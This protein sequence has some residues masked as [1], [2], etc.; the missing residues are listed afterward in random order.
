MRLRETMEKRVLL[1]LPVSLYEKV[2]KIATIEYR[3]VPSVIREC[4]S[5]QIEGE[6][7]TP[8]E[9]ASIER[10]EGEYRQGKCVKWREVAQ[11]LRNLKERK[12]YFLGIE[13]KI[14]ELHMA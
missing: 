12:N 7:P 9:L 1:S 10:G 5:S 4:I 6:N 8:E 11:G 13:E 2:S 3:T 14:S